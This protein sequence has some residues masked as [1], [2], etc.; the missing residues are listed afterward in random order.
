G[1]GMTEEY[2]SSIFEPFV[3]EE[4]GY[5]RR[6]EGNGLGLALVKKYCDLNNVR[7]RIESEKNVGS[8]FILVFPGVLE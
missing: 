5:S 8:K 2:L 1:I 3:Q 6:F 7:I 4:G